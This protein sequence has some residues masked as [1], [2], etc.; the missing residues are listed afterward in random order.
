MYPNANKLLKLPGLP[1]FIHVCYPIIAICD[2]RLMY[3]TPAPSQISPLEP[4]GIELEAS[5]S[6]RLYRNL[7]PCLYAGFIKRILKRK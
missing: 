4:L 6:S 3:I 1:F 5:H 7:A 2:Y